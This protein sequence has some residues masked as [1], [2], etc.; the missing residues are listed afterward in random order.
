[1]IKIKLLIG[2]QNYETKKSKFGLKELWKFIS[3]HKRKT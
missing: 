3:A 1:M 2:S